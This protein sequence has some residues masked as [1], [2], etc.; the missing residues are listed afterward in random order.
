MLLYS[1]VISSSPGSCYSQHLLY[2]S[3]NNQY[4]PQNITR[5]HQ[6]FGHDLGILITELTTAGHY[7]MV[8]G[9]FNSDYSQLDKWMNDL[10]MIDL[11]KKKHGPC[12]ITYQRSSKD[13]LD[14]VFGDP[15]FKIKE[16]GCLSFQRLISDHRGIWFD[17]PN[18]YLLGFNPPPLNHPMARRLKTEDPR[19]VNRYC[20]KLHEMCQEAQLY[21]RMDLLHSQ[22]SHPLLRYQIEEYEELDA[23][24]CKMMDKAETSCRKLHMGTVSWSPTYKL[25]NLEIEYWRMRRSHFLGM[26]RNVRQ[27]IVLQNRLI[28]TYNS[29]LDLQDIEK[30]SG[31]LIKRGKR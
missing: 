13:P 20:N 9:D 4:I 17:I 18:E 5:P 25:I 30:I 22:V 7:V 26:H 1:P 28:I 23:E 6:L 3:E 29:N 27:L 2:M 16:G 31:R 12:P 19:C 10:G 15:Y 11:L 14:C 24:L 8:Q 21:E